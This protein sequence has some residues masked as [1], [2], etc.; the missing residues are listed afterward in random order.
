MYMNTF[1]A[2]RLNAYHWL[3]VHPVPL[4]VTVAAAVVR[5]QVG[6]G[7]RRADT[8]SVIYCQPNVVIVLHAET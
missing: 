7:Q 3:P 1:L 6:V 2:R 5:E 4:E 8:A